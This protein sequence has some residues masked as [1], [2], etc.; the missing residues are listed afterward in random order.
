MFD[1]GGYQSK[2]ECLI[3]G[4]CLMELSSCLDD[5]PSKNVAVTSQVYEIVGAEKMRILFNAERM[6]ETGNYKLHTAHH[7]SHNTELAD[8]VITDGANTNLSNS[9]IAAIVVNSEA[10][11]VFQHPHINQLVNQFVPNPVV[12]GFESGGLK[13]L[14]EIREVTT[15]FVKFD[16]YDSQ[17]YKDLLSLHQYFY[18]AQEILYEYGAFL[19]QFLVDDK[20]DRI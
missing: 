1:L 15:M 5:A 16:S 20:G 13:Y 18:V 17:R 4:D 14:A 2:F 12:Y 9:E 7:P 19:R 11:K 8:G 10:L 6:P 3:S